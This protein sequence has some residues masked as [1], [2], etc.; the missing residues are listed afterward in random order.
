MSFHSAETIG[1]IHV[2]HNWEYANITA[3]QAATGFVSADLYK[4]AVQLDDK[5]IWMLTATTPTWKC[6]CGAAGIA[7]SFYDEANGESNKTG[8]GWAEKLKLTFTPTEAAYYEISFSCLLSISSKDKGLQAR[9]QI[10]DSTTKKEILTSFSTLNYGD[11]S[12]MVYSGNFVV[13]L[14]V[15]SHDID[16]D[17]ATAD[18]SETV[19]AKE[20]VL[21]AR[22]IG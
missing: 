15:A 14:S 11:G 3:R 16:L 20:A 12:W 21:A 7:P 8:S 22:V 19:Y 13:Q 4:F 2:T 17:F 9:I 18:V 1:S 6:V 10:D 5:T